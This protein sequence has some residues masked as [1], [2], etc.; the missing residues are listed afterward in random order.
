MRTSRILLAT[1]REGPLR[2]RDRQSPAHDPGGGMVRRLAAG[3]YTW[4]PLGL[5]GAAQDRETSCAR[6]WTVPGAQE[7]LM[8]AVAARRALEWESGRWDHFGPELL[9]LRDRHERDFC[10][11]PTH[12][13]VITDIV[14]R[15]VRSYRQLP[16]NLYQIQTKFRGR[17]SR[18]PLRGHCGAREFIMKDALLLRSRRGGKP[19]QLRRRCATPTGACFAP[20]GP[21]LPGGG[22]RLGGHRGQAARRSF[23][24]LADS[25]GGTDIAFQR[26]GGPTPRN[27]EL[28]P[29]PSAAP[30]PPAATETMREVEDS[31]RSHHRGT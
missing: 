12:E 26:R 20:D 24:V 7:V 11:G 16:L 25:G 17:G 30:R 8:P 29:R 31:G 22:G 13:E 19:P 21:R 23:H 3:L 28:T 6:R 10:V 5:P 14:R 15:E 27:L 18:P 2:R 4:L 9:R 1:E